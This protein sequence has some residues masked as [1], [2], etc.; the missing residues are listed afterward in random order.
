VKNAEVS[1]IPLPE[2]RAGLPCLGGKLAVTTDRL[3]LPPECGPLDFDWNQLDMD[4]R[5]HVHHTYRSPARLVLTPD[6][7]LSV[8]K[9]P[10]PLIGL[11]VLLLTTDVRL[12]PGEFA[13]Y[14]TLFNLIL[15]QVRT[16]YTPERVVVEWFV[17]SHPFFKL[18]HW[19]IH[20]MLRRFNVTQY[21]E[22]LPLRRIR[23]ELR[24]RG[25]TFDSDPPDYVTCNRMTNRIHPPALPEPIRVRL[26]SAAPGDEARLRA[27]PIELL[28]RREI[29]D[30]WTVWPAA[31]PHEGG[32]LAEGRRDG[33]VIACPWH[34]LRFA[35][36]S[37]SAAA[38]AGRVGE[39][40]VRL[41]GDSLVVESAG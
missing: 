2:V 4:H 5:L 27:G 20:R 22:D 41:D 14:Y 32:P 37:L 8:I 21:P 1:Q 17:L 23:T 39:V 25:Y 31:C 19:P 34:G 6:A 29:E 7:V 9:F 24:S 3:E 15:V 40:A 26:P 36:T 28:V 30:R 16:T 11:K 10:L 13:Q 38:P 12:A 18:L 35:G 33:Q